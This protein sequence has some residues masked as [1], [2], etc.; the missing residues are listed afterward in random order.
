MSREISTSLYDESGFQWLSL[1]KILDKSECLTIKLTIN[2]KYSSVI[3]F[4]AFN[5]F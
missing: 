5:Y 3:V 2:F 1:I 4:K